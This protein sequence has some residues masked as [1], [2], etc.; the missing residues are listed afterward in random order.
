MYSYILNKSTTFLLHL[1]IK[2]ATDNSPVIKSDTPAAERFKNYFNYT[3]FM[4]S[5][6]I[7]WLVKVVVVNYH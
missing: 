4:G 6:L 3:E 1:P 5:F 2:T 7:F